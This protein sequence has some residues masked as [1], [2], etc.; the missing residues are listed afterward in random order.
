MIELSG[1]YKITCLFNK[2]IYIGSSANTKRRLKE[3]V[4]L[5]KRNKHINIHLQDA[6]NKYGEQNF[7][8]E[9]I[10]KMHDIKQLPIREKW[11]LD[12]TQCYKREVGFNISRDPQGLNGTHG[13]I[14]LTGQKFGR[15][16]VLKQNGKDKWGGSLWLCLC[17]CGKQKT[18]KSNLLR[19]GCTRS[20]GCLQYETRGDNGKSNIKHGLS[21]T[22]EYNRWKQ[23]NER[24]SNE[25]HPQYKDYGRRNI[26]VC[27]RWSK[28]N[29]K[30]F[31]NFFEDI[32]EIPKGL[33]LD[34][35]ENNRFYSK[36]NCRLIS[37]KEQARNKRNN[38]YIVVKGKKQ[39]LVEVAEEYNI[40]YMAL[41]KRLY[42]YNWSIKKALTTPIRRRKK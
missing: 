2:K 38:L 41:W 9:I 35:I 27:Y 32:G 40:P 28:K 23:M 7:R 1:I 14:D 22:I 17:E 19:R 6:W 5:L 37:M 36:K 20:C 25:N 4:R 16:T 31:E 42:L 15:L 26:K 18:I 30:G 39:L 21:K 29:P 33:T 24:C 11:W 34:R 12:T 3:H 13:F 8:Y 10:E